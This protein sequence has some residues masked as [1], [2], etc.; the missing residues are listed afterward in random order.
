MMTA[1]NIN[2][3]TPKGIAKQSAKATGKAMVEDIRE[4][5]KKDTQLYENLPIEDKPSTSGINNIKPDK[6]D[7]DKN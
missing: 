5:L 1:H 3:I 7:G 4:N 6:S 2:H